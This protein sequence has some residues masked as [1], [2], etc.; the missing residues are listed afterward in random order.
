MP[1]SAY[2]DEEKWN[3][4]LAK[5]GV[6]ITDLRDKPYN[7]IFHLVT[8]ADGA[9]AFYTLENNATRS[10]SP[11]QARELD[12][13]TQKAWLGHPHMYVFDNSSDFE[14]KLQRLIDRIA[15]IV[16]LPTNLTRRAAKFLL[17]ARPDLKSFPSGVDFHVFDASF[18]SRM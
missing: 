10:E 12:N 3:S 17:N 5:R 1:G 16:G 8:A 9:E 7:A 18:G 6:D 11:E 13:K 4:I 2:L 14:G 15:K